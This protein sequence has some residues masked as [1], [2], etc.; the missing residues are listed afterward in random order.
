MKFS[1]SV[2]EK[3]STTAIRVLRISVVTYY[4]DND[5]FDLMASLE[6]AFEKCE[7]TRFEVVLV[8]NGYKEKNE[9]H[10]ALEEKYSFCEIIIAGE[11]LGYGRAHN[12]AMSAN[13][14][15]HLILNP[16]IILQEN[17]LTVALNFLSSH[18]ECGLLSPLAR[19]RNGERQ[20]LCKRYP[21]V[22]TLLLR[23]FAPTFIRK[24]L[25][26]RLAN[27]NMA[28]DITPHSVY[29]NP[30]IV[31]GC[32]MFFRNS[33]LQELKGFDPDYFLYF[34]DTDLSWRA[35][36]LTKVAYV[37]QVEV[38]HHGGNASRKGLKHILLF[39]SSM[40]KFFH[41]NGWKMV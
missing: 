2:A 12:L 4:I 23:G 38:V 7:A 18:P 30:P 3:Q 37:P 20:F 8:E 10:R 24:I 28:E 35:A 9:Y 26:K 33:I 29:W 41:K 13:A 36:R 1:D 34:E 40:I 15:Y 5:I 22:F 32:F 14:D 11:N 21:S 25:K 17:T 27:Y 19:W 16:D 39:T 31:S 6:I